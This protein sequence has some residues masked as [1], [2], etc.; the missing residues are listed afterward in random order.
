MEQIKVCTPLWKLF[1]YCAVQEV[2]NELLGFTFTHTVTLSGM[3]L[4]PLPFL[5]TV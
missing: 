3:F 5:T 2:I 1:L 4:G